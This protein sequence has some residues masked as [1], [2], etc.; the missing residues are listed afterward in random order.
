MSSYIESL[1]E[2]V[3]SRRLLEQQSFSKDMLEFLRRHFSEKEGQGLFAQIK[4]ISCSVCNVSIASERLQRAK[5]GRF[6]KCTYCSR[7][8]Y[9]PHKIMLENKSEGVK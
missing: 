4:G 3:L 2:E 7:F 1:S 5:M 9:M 6:I 8:L